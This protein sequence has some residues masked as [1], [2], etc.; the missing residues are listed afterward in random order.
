MEAWKYTKGGLWKEV[1]VSLMKKIWKEGRI[2]KDWR[3]SII[4]LLYKKGDKK[5]VKNYR[6]ISLLCTAYKIYAEILRNKLEKEAKMKEMIPVTQARFRKERA[7]TDFVPHHVIK[8]EERKREEQGKH[9]CC[10]RI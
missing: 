3:K 6:G 7:T 9:I 8:N 10:L 1:V 4:V 2:P 5:L